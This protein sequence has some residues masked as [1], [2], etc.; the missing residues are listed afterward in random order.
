[1]KYYL[2]N[3]GAGFLGN[4]PF[5]WANGGNGYTADIDEAQLF[6]KG[7]AQSI[8]KSTK[9]THKWKIW[10]EKRVKSAIYR[11]VDMQKLK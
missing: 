8:V 7:E 11:T 1:M 5:W 4:S 9:G 6:E 3:I 2:Q 10:S